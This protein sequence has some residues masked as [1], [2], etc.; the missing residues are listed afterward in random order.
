MSQFDF[1]ISSGLCY[2]LDSVADGISHLQSD[3]IRFECLMCIC[4]RVWYW[5][6]DFD[7]ELCIHRDHA[8]QFDP[9]G[10]IN[11]YEAF[12]NICFMSLQFYGYESQYF[13]TLLK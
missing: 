6:Y 13:G 3:L 10:G 11:G 8:C 9:V 4:V 5:G 7:T 1:L 2:S 12:R